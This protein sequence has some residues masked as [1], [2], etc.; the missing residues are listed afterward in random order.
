MDIFKV[1][2]RKVLIYVP[3]FK[4]T[5]YILIFVKKILRKTL[6]KHKYI[7][8]QQR[9]SKRAKIILILLVSTYIGTYIICPTFDVFLEI[10]HKVRMYFFIFFVDAAIALFYWFT[11]SDM[12]IGITLFIVVIIYI[13]F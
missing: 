13:Y 4:S 6:K 8:T 9:T 7:V 2:F 10:D 1:Y 11:T 12:V 3:T 5:F